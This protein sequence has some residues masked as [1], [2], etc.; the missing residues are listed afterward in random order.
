M[1]HIDDQHDTIDKL[2]GK[3]IYSRSVFES[4]PL[5]IGTIIYS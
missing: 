5:Q 1:K 4:E 3:K 2:I